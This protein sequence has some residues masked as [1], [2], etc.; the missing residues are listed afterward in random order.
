MIYYFGK[1]R[2]VNEN[3]LNKLRDDFRVDLTLKIKAL[4]KGNRQQVALIAVLSSKPDLL[5]LDE[6]SIG[7]DP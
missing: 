3:F 7:L 2:P 1:F 6:P 4:S 5:I